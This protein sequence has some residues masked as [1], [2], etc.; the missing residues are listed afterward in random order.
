MILTLCRQEAV[1][2]LSHRYPFV[3][4][5]SVLV[6]Q[7][8]RMLVS[9]LNPPETTLDIVTGPQLWAQG[10][11]VGLRFGTYLLLVFGAMGFSQEFSLGTVKTIL[12]LPVRRW[13][14]AAAKLLFLVLLALGML[15][16]MAAVGIAVVALTTGWNGVI[17]EEIVL[18]GAGTVWRELSV[19]LALTFVFMLPLCALS[20]L[21]GIHFTSSGA[22]VGTALLLGIGVE[23]AVG[24]SGHGRFIFLYHLHRP[25]GIIEKIGKGLPYQW[26]SIIF[27]GLGSSLIAFALFSLWTALR[28]ERMDITV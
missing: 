13:N 24:L 25:I 10:M 3:L 23:A 5:G 21:I 9:A 14:W 8:A 11:G 19:A 12:V 16:I 27:W 17:R 1:K 15:L 6:F 28:L 20:L 26:E 22:A 7:V 4:F 2:L 18:Y